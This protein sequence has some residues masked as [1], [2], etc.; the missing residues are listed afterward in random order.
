[1]SWD[2]VEGCNFYG[3]WVRDMNREELYALI[4]YLMKDAN[5]QRKECVTLMNALCDTKRKK[6]GAFYSWLF[7][8]L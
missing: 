2:H 5:S 6:G 8:G 3:K 7:G 4:D 1:M